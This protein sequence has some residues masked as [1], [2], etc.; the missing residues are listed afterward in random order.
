MVSLQEAEALSAQLRAEG[1]AA[2]QLW[3]L[4]NRDEVIRF[5]GSTPAARRKRKRWQNAD[6]RARLALAAHQQARLAAAILAFGDPRGLG[7]R[8]A[9]EAASRTAQEIL[10]TVWQWPFATDPPGPE[11]A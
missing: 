6:L 4:Q 11:W 10:D 2:W 3:A 9:T 5:L 8:Q 7:Y 1:P